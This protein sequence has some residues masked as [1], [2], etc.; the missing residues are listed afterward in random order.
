M[1]DTLTIATAEGVR[2]Y[3]I[4][5][6]NLV[7]EAADRHHTSHLATAALG[8]AMSGALM[9]AATMK[10]GERIL[11]KLKGDGPMG[12]VVAEAQGTSVRGYVGEPD[13]FMPLKNGKL[14]IGGALGQ[15]TITLTRYLQNGE[16]FTGHAELADG[17]IATDITNYLYMSEQTPSSVAL[18]VLVDKDGKVLA[19]GGY[20]IQAMPGCD[21]EVL[22]KLGNNVAVTPYVTQLLELGY[23]PEKII[24]V[25]ARGLDFD[26]KESMPVKFSCACSK[27]KI[28]N[29]L[30][31]L[32]QDDI[33]YLTEQPDTEVHCQY[34]NKVYHFSSEE[35]KQL[36][37]N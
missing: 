19:A 22:E 2:I 32:S 17:E 9:L 24:E 34:C 7:Q 6:K 28:L 27:D 5:T 11:L 12:E 35:L 20:F 37:T 18:G 23:T 15:G 31:A 14:D 25:L 26:I 13:V 10:D 4:T 33:D 3:A 8:R 30:A 36:K 16:S 21:E 29:M 1:E